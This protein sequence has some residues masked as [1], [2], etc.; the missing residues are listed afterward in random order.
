MKK[1]LL[2]LSVAIA[3]A[4][5]VG[6]MAD[7]GMPQQTHDYYVQQSGSVDGGIGSGNP[8]DSLETTQ[9]PFQIVTCDGSAEHP[10]DFN[11]LIIMV[12]RLIR[13]LLYLAIPLTLGMVLYTGWLYISANGETG[14]LEKAKKMFI[15]VLLGLFWIGASY[16]VVYTVLDKFVS[17]NLSDSSK[18]AINILKGN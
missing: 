16:I 3:C 8:R 11:A 15:P 9:N 2:A 6:A 10:C 18:D 1:T 12:N 13:L 14:Q 7:A 17:K 5:P 4:A